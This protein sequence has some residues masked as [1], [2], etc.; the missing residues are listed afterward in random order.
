MTKI[1][2]KEENNAWAKQ[3]PG[4][5]TSACLAIRYKEQVLMVKAKYKDHW[6]FPSSI[7]DDKESPKRQHYARPGR[8]LE[9]ILE[10]INVV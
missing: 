4:K 7:V 10:I 9:F 3:L 6:I 8:K 2:T 5:M 1:F